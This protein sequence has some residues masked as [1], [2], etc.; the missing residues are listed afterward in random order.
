VQEKY[1]LVIFFFAWVVFGGIWRYVDF[2]FYR[3]I[4]SFW[5][6]KKMHIIPAS[7]LDFLILTFLL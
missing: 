5:V 2:G 3:L 1:Q 6:Y 7:L 4:L